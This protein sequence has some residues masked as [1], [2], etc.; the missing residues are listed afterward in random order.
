MDPRSFDPARYQSSM[1]TARRRLEQARSMQEPDCVPVTIST[2]GSFYC[3]LF[4]VNIRDYYRAA[5][6][7]PDLQIELQLQGLRWAFEELRDD[8]T[9]C[10][11]YLDLGPIGEAFAFDLD[12]EYPDDTSPWI[13]RAMSV[14]EAAEKLQVTDPETSPGV[15]KVYRAYEALRARAEALGVKVGVSGGLGIH[16]PLSAA[17]GILDVEEVLYYLATEPQLV[18]RI[19]EKLLLS[20]I[21]LRDYQDRY[22]GT[23]TTSLGLAD[24]HSAFISDP[25][26]RQH[27]MPYNMVLYG[28]YGLQERYL[29]ADGPNQHHYQTY[30]E[31]MRLTSMDIGGFSDFDQAKQILGGKVFFSGGL[32]CKDLYGDFAAAKSAVDHALQVGMPGGGY[33]LAVGGETYTGVNPQTL[34][35][36]VSYAREAGRYPATR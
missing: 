4:G 14:P 2:G 22:F 18:H 31:V 21:R 3:R 19:F 15:Q 33:A 23:R 7:N 1:A 24:D 25:M 32:N 17:C 26:Y 12:V 9:G 5:F 36:V 13:G 10:G 20:F 11:L 16:P 29:H 8:R 6:D 28:R 30:A 35:Q 34:C 27:V